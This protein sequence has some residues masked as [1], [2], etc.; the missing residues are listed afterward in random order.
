MGDG[1]VVEVGAGVKEKN[2]IFQGHLGVGVVL[3]FARHLR[4]GAGSE[5]GRERELRWIFGERER[6]WIL[7]DDEYYQYGRDDD[8]DNKEGEEHVKENAKQKEAEGVVHD[9]EFVD[10]E[11][12]FRS[13]VYDDEEVLTYTFNS[14]GEKVDVGIEF[15]PKIDMKNPT[16]M[17]GQMFGN[18]QIL[19][20]ALLE[21]AIQHGHEYSF[22]RNET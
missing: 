5:R 1:E 19:R 9:E 7:E 13:T 11:E 18:A 20:E 12:V 3:C 6:A 16:F 8:A 22:A 21:H 14:D 4:P 15:N 17:E 2:V 10:D